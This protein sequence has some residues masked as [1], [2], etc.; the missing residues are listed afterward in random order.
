[1]S[2]V[3]MCRR[4]DNCYPRLDGATNIPGGGVYIDFA[5]SLEHY[6]SLWQVTSTT[7]NTHGWPLVRRP[8]MDYKDL[9]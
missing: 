5:S 7:H 1:M 4:Y 6:P 2:R 8:F 3:M 9:R